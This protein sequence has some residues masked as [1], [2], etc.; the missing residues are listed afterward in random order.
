MPTVVTDVVS[1][2]S[3]NSATRNQ[4]TPRMIGIHHS[5]VAM[6]A[7]SRRSLFRDVVHGPLLGEMS[8]VDDATRTSPTRGMQA[9]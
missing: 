1:N 3:T 9:P 4:A 7:A 5:V 6:A 2:R 8:V